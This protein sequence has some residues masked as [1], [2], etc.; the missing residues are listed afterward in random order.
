MCSTC[1]S[2]VWGCEIVCLWYWWW[3]WE[4]WGRAGRVVVCYLDVG[5]CTVEE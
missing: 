5:I 1:W 2:E 4:A 3:N